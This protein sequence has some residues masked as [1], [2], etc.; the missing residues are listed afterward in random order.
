MLEYENLCKR[1]YCS[2]HRPDQLADLKKKYN[3]W[4]KNKHKFDFSIACCNGAIRVW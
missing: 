2:L 1:N 3:T 4:W